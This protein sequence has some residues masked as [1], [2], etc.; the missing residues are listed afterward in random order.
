M[1]ASDRVTS[2]TAGFSVEGRPLRYA[3]VGA[4]GHVTTDGLAGGP[5]R[6]RP[7]PR[8]GDVRG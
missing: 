4:P 1:T 7:A 8:S 3:I 2:G 5:S 6:D